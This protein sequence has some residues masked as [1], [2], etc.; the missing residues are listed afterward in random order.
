MV[1]SF[2]Y[3]GIYFNSKGTIT[4]TKKHLTEQA[5]KAMISLLR[6]WRQFDIPVDLMLDLFDK[7]VTPILSCG[8]EVW[9]YENVDMIERI[10]LKFCKILLCVKKSTANYLVYGQLRQFPLSVSIY[11]RLIKFWVK[12]VFP[13]NHNRISHI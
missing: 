5:S 7:S 11:A 4:D 2:K 6:K 1:Q 9:D 8:C 13:E 3:L 10:Y 12:I